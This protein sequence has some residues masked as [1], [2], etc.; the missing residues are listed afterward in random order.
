MISCT[1]YRLGI[2]V[3]AVLPGFIETPMTAVVPDKIKKKFMERI[4][5]QRIGKPEEVAEVI[6][7]LASDKSSYINGTFIEITGGWQ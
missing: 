5:S 1:F 7:F 4:S 6:A 3:N 2:R